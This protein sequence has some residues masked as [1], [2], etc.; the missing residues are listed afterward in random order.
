MNFALGASTMSA[1]EL[2]LW[3]TKSSRVSVFAVTENDCPELIMS[4][5]NSLISAEILKMKLEK[6]NEIHTEKH[7]RIRRSTHK[8]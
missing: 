8:L 6:E 3:P 1:L 4:K 7:Q 2:L 5:V